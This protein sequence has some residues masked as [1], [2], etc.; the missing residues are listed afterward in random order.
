MLFNHAFSRG[1]AERQ[2]PR[3]EFF[4]SLSPLRIRSERAQVYSRL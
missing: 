4:G 3:R 2:V 1:G